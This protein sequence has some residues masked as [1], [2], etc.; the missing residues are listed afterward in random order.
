[1]SDQGTLFP[2]DDPPDPRGDDPIA[3]DGHGYRVGAPRGWYGDRK[4]WQ[5]FVR[6]LR[7][8]RDRRRDE[9]AEG[10]E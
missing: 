1:M 6:L 3:I 8:K 9:T 7:T 2:D 4:A 5:R 10:R